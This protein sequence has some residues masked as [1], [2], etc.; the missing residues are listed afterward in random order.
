VSMKTSL[1]ASVLASLLTMPVIVQAEARL[2]GIAHLSVDHLDNGEQRRTLVSSN[3]SRI[4]IRGSLEK[5]PDLAVLYQLE[6]SIEWGTDKD[7][8]FGG[9]RD[10]Y[11]GLKGRFGRVLAGRLPYHNQW[12]GKANLFA[13]QIGDSKN[14]MNHA[15]A[16]EG[17]S[18]PGSRSDKTLQYITPG[19][20]G[21][22]LALTFVPNGDFDKDEG[23]IMGV[24][25][26]YTN[27]P[28]YLNLT[29]FSVSAVTA[30]DPTHTAFVVN[31]DSGR[32]KAIA[33][34][35]SDKKHAA[36]DRDAWTVGASVT[37]GPGTAKLQY[38]HA[39]DWS[40]VGDSSADMVA[41]GYD[42][43]L[44]DQTTVWVAYARTEN[45]D[46]AAYGMSGGGHGAGE[47][48]LGAGNHPSGFGIGLIHRF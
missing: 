8:A 45:G 13:D 39:D 29:H 40:H 36:G 9:S 32:Y 30:S 26:Q 33:G 23:E 35:A 34:W 17:G 48:D 7:A 12:A 5:G 6:G 46:N 4:G 42:Y 27:G 20:R 22:D 21:F 3:S 14:I 43:P 25:G 28:L 24:R 11:L 19:V 2:Y 31:Y 16:V 38:S 44:D 1:A 18:V 15:G 41:M 37:L 47:I 10:S